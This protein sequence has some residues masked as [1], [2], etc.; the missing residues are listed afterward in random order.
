MSEPVILVLVTL[1]YLIAVMVLGFYG[2]RK[3]KTATDYLLAGR[4]AHPYI[5]ALSYGATF[6]S[7]SAIV[8]FGGAAAFFGMGLLWLTFLNIFVGIFIA[9]VFFGKRTRRMGHNLNAHTFPELLGRRFNSK[10]IQFFTALVIFLFMP[11]YAS[12]VLLGAARFIEHTFA[13]DVKQAILIFSLI[14]ALYVIAGG[15]KGVM[16]TDAL[17]GTLMLIGMLVLVLYA[18]SALGGVV[19]AHRELSRLPSEIEQNAAKVIQKYNAQTG[20]NLTPDLVAKMGGLA[21]KLGT[22]SDKEKSDYLAS[23]ADEA[24]LLKRFGAFMK[25]KPAGIVSF[26]TLRGIEKLGHRGWTRMPATGTTFWY[27]LVTTVILGVG[28]G[29]LAQPQLAVRFM[30]VKSGRELNR[31]VLV[32]GIFILMMTGVAFVVGALSNVSLYQGLGEI[33]FVAAGKNTDNIIPV[34]INH[35]MPKWFVVLFMLTLLSAAMSTLSSQFHTMGTSIGRDVYEQVILG[36]ER[37]GATVL[38][39]RI[40]IVIAIVV[41]VVLAYTL[42]GSIIPAATALFFGLCASSFLPMLV[43]ALFTRGITK[44][45][46][47]WG[48][49]A[50][51]FASM[52][53]LLVVQMV[54]AKHPALLAPLLFGRDSMLDF[55]WK[56]V[57]ALIVGLPLS[58][59]VT[60]VVSM[61][62][63][64]IPKEHIDL[65]F[66]GI[67]KSA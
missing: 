12:V 29:V 63:K 49:C 41:T 19:S 33:S 16:Y 46:A 11:L 9:F 40:G 24:A 20:E 22:M 25:T 21:K 65:C 37:R 45:G 55:P 50:G 62:T 52:F 43:G 53:W 60:I 5:M 28:I 38:I 36:G 4:G 42:P 35:V 3:T 17:Q 1:A 27:F 66:R 18:Y 13:L 54:K 14:I 31:A 48:M 51:F 10:F 44:A 47:I 67:G 32:G 15:L 39:T 56:Y 8:G 6:I 30:T 61:V 2:Y 26:L 7:T 59:I 58:T 57:D 34:Y 23:H 64:K